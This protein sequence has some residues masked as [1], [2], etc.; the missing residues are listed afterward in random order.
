MKLPVMAPAAASLVQC[1]SLALGTD[2]PSLPTRA[3]LCVRSAGD[4]PAPPAP[5]SAP[6]PA[7]KP[8]NMV[9]LARDDDLTEMEKAAVAKAPKRPK[10]PDGTYLPKRNV[11]K[12]KRRK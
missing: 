11:R 4:A 8:F 1:S 6:T 2:R 9:P 7:I 5:A 3:D 12:N 10:K